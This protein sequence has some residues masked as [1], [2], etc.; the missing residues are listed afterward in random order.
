MSWALRNNHCRSEGVHL[1]VWMDNQKMDVK[2][3]WPCC[4][5]FVVYQGINL[6]FPDQLPELYVPMWHFRT[7]SV[8]ELHS[9]DTEMHRA[10][11]EWPNILLMIPL[12]TYF[13]VNSQEHF[14]I[15]LVLYSGLHFNVFWVAF[16]PGMLWTNVKCWQLYF[17]SWW[18]LTH[19]SIHSPKTCSLFIYHVPLF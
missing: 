3:T 8:P 6:W 13:V 11:V 7:G 2:F 15:A 17:C 9:S 16:H 10:V 4:P 18:L 12:Q 14:K 1:C 5:G 19:L